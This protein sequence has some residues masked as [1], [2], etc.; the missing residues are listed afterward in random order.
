MRASATTRPHGTRKRYNHGPDQD[1]QPGKGCRCPACTLA[2]NRSQNVYRMTR[3]RRGLLMVDAEPARQ[4]VLRLREAGLS[5][6]AIE[7]LSGV[8]REQIRLLVGGHPTEGRP[9]TRRILAT[10]ERALLAVQ[11]GMQPTEGMVPTAGSRRR[12]QGLTFAGW[13]TKLLAEHTGIAHQFLRNLMSDT[14]VRRINAKYAATIARV[15][16][17]LETVD[18]VT[19]GARPKDVDAARR[20]ARQRGWL[21]LAAWDDDLIEMPDDVLEAELRRRVADMDM[22]DLARCD[23]ARRVLK[24]RSPLIV[25]ASQEYRRRCSAR[26][27]S[28]FAGPEVAA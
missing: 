25:A 11:P 16:A 14:P 6:C 13:P 20:R 5:Y 2:N 12:L 24:E 28:A 7:R 17:R 3:A 23:R 1:G 26:Y 10:N 15:A 8:H 18:P 21:P 9:P 22:T 19:A 4:H 27:R